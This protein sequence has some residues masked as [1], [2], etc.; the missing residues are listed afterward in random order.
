MKRFPITAGFTLLELLVAMALLTAVMAGLMTAMRSFAQVEARIDQQALR[1]EEFR[2][3]VRFVRRILGA[4]APRTV[5]V[6]GGSP[7]QI[8]FAGKAAEIEWIGVMPARHGAGGLTRFHL[9]VGDS[10]GRRALILEYAPL[11]NLD[12]PLESEPLQSHVLATDVTSIALRYRDSDKPDE[13]WLDD[14]PIADRLPLFVSLQVQTA[15][16]IWP[17][18]RV[19]VTPAVGNKEPDRSGAEG[20]GR[21][22]PRPG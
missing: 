11:T 15:G 6:D 18:L 10:D 5:T 8:A 16:G 20:K 2:S 1:D 13:E 22:T 4:M 19:A 3:S 21:P 12:K 7:R 14:W 17:E 9:F